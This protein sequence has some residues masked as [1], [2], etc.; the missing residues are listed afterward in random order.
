MD[1][2]KDRLIQECQEAVWTPMQESDTAQGRVWVFTVHNYTDAQIEKI[3]GSVGDVLSY[4]IFGKETCPD[5]GRPHLQGYLQCKGKPRRRTLK[6]S[7]G[8][9][10]V[11]MHLQRAKGTWQQ[12][13]TYCTKEGDWIEK[14]VPDKDLGKKGKRKDLD[15]AKELLDKDV[16][17]WE[18][19][20]E[21]FG[22]WARYPNLFGRYKRLKP[23]EVVIDYELGDFPLDTI[24]ELQHLVMTKGSVIIWGPAGTGKTHLAKALLAGKAL[25]VSHMDQLKEFDNKRHSGI[26]FDDMDFSH[27]PREPQIHIVDQD[28]DR[29]LHCRYDIA[30]IPRKTTKIFTTNKEGGEIFLLSDPAI[31]R[32]VSPYQVEQPL[33]E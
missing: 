5:T 21:A 14:G 31:A 12:N 17:E 20:Q 16:T 33:F 2:E 10:L 26:I 19:A 9:S 24:E 29:A 15:R 13:Y 27:L 7:F 18:F 6:E 4:V 1:E 23:K 11:T 25:F 32:R 30:N 3:L 22:A 28:D 8:P